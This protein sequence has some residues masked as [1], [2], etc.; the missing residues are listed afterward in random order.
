M[1]GVPAPKPRSLLLV[2]FV[3]AGLYLVG[4]SLRSLLVKADCTVGGSDPGTV[5]VVD[6]APVPVQ[7]SLASGIQYKFTYPAN[8]A[9]WTSPLRATAVP[10]GSIFTSGAGSVFGDANGDGRVR[11]DD[12]IFIRNRLGTTDTASDLNGSGTVDQ[13]DLVLCRQALG[14]A[15]DRVTVYVEG[16]SPSAALCDVPIQLLTDADHDQTFTLAETK[17]TTVAAI[18]ISPTAGGLGTP[19]NI[20]IQPAVAP[21][22]FDSATTAKWSGVYEPSVGSPTD[23]F[24][25]SYSRWEFHESS[26]SEATVF[27]GEGTAT[28]APSLG[29]LSGTGTLMGSVGLVLSGRTLTRSFA[30]SLQAGGVTWEKLTYPI[31]Y[32]EWTIGPPSLA[33]Q[34]THV[35]VMTWSDPTSPPSEETLVYL[36]ELHHAV[37]VRIPE[38]APAVAAAPDFILV[39]LISL[40]SSHTEIDR[41]SAVRLGRVPNDGDAAHIVYSTHLLKPIVLVDVAMNPSAYPNVT[42]LHGIDNGYLLAVPTGH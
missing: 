15:P 11:L 18:S 3:L 35:E 41:R 12:L 7:F 6:E 25:V 17:G 9:L 31:D 13:N 1:A 5:I 38:T 10:S 27:I 16:L 33:G 39:D 34:P 4:A 20:T 22:T 28:N 2:S 26:A 37:V 42:V 21:L 36:R 30:F 14:S 32:L 19:I 8:V 40:N 29:N 23:T 24:Q